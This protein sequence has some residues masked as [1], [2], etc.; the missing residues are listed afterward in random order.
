MNCFLFP[1]ILFM[2]KLYVYDKIP[3]NIDCAGLS[4][5]EIK[6]ISFFSGNTLS[7][8]NKFSSNYFIPFARDFA[9]KVFTTSYYKMLMR[10]IEAGY[11][12][13]QELGIDKNG[14]PYYYSKARGFC[15]CYKLSDESIKDLRAGK[16]TKNLIQVPFLPSPK[17]SPEFFTVTTDSDSPLI[18]KI[19]RAYGGISIDE[20]WQ[21]YSSPDT[22]Y[23]DYSEHLIAKSYAR[24][25]NEGKIKVSIPA[26]GRIYHPLICLHRVLRPF[27]R[28]D[29]A[30]LMG[31]DGKAFHPHLLATFLAGEKKS[32]YVNFLAGND[33]YE[34]FMDS[35]YSDYGTERNRIKK[36]FQLFCGN[37]PLFGKP[38]EIYNWYRKRFPEIICRKEELKAAGTTV[39]MTL[40]NLESDIFIKR[41]FANADFWMLPMHDGLVVKPDETYRAVEFCGQQIRDYLRFDIKLESK[42]LLRHGFFKE[43]VFKKN[44]LKEL[45]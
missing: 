25:I 29:G 43:S 1:R 36:C 18:A 39:Q 7:I 10:L 32:E 4:E 11:L 6:L 40:Q 45:Q 12:E 28:K 27:V 3:I 44:R 20:A 15:R 2:N 13:P 23:L 8:I 34:E 22:P 35:S 14:N 41:I 17:K 42:P 5:R 26:N 30:F 19:A 24:Q 31:V 21:W 37:K 38:M 33:I 16:Y 9:V